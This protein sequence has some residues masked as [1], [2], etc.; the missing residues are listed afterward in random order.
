MGCVATFEA[1]TVTITYSDLPVLCGLKSPDANLWTLPFLPHDTASLPT[2]SAAYALSSDA[3]FVKFTHAALGSLSLTT[4]AKAVRRGYL[5]SYPRLT[6][7]MLTAHPPVTIA[8][9]QGHLDQHRQGQKST[10]IPTTIFP[11]DDPD[12]DALP[13][14]APKHPTAYTQLVLMS[15]T[16]HSDL[17]GRFSVPSH[18]GA[19]Y[20]FV[21]VLDGYINANQTPLRIYYS[22][23]KKTLN[24][25]AHLGRKPAFQRL[26]NETSGSLETFALENNISIQYCPPHIHRSLK[27]ER[28]IRTLKNHFISTLCTAAPEFPMA[29][30]DE[31]LPQ[32]EICLNHLLTYSPNPSVSAYAGLHGGALDF[33][34]HPIAPAGT[35]VLIHDKPGVRSSW[36]PHG[37]PGYYLGPAL[38]H[39]RSY[40]VWSSAT[41]ATR[42]SDTL[43]W[44][45]HGIPIPG[46]SPRDTLHAAITLLHSAL[47]EF[48]AQ[49]GAST[50]TWDLRNPFTAQFRTPSVVH[51]TSA[52]TAH[53]PSSPLLFLSFSRLLRRTEGDYRYRSSYSHRTENDTTIH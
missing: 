8:T 19:Q 29:L 31:L 27:A 17:T 37:V 1:S 40:R 28:A 5:N 20:I 9:A 52:G 24:F 18:N 43:A 22:I 10:A 30:W 33:L 13:L 41:K 47:T 53:H 38:Q 34:R 39:Y 21:S 11:I 25:F 50:V 46:P 36:T 16:L 42:I 2:V 45:P 4:L 49:P 3:D 12:E 26:D 23:Q 44:F 48:A 35:R 32:A 7:G 14:D 51:G 15:D 6:S